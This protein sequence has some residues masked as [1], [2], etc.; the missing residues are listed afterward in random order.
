[1]VAIK[2]VELQKDRSNEASR[3]NN[4]RDAQEKG[5]IYGHKVSSDE[6][7]L[8]LTQLLKQSFEILID[9]KRSARTFAKNSIGVEHFSTEYS[10][11]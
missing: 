7:K 8:Y 9:K 4:S 11:I 6:S 2:R 10:Y 3:S 5:N 1:M